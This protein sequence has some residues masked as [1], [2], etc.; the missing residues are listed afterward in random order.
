MSRRERPKRNPHLV[1]WKR[2]GDWRKLAVGGVTGAL[3]ALLLITPLGPDKIP[4]REGAVAP[5]E[6]RSPRYLQFR[7]ERETERQ[8]K[9][10]AAKPRFSARDKSMSM[11]PTNTAS[12]VGSFAQSRSTS[13]PRRT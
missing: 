5:E 6:I 2:W 7:D 3:I 10:A 13:P 12:A 9:R 1:I 4:L 8:R 11:V